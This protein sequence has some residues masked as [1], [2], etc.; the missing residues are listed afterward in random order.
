MTDPN[1]PIPPA[2]A[3]DEEELDMDEEDEPK[4]APRAKTTAAP[5]SGLVGRAWAA[6]K[7]LE[8]RIQQLTR[9]RVARVLKMARKPEPEEFRQSATIVLVGIAVI[10]ALGFFTYLFM[11]WL[12]VAI[13]AK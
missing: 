4:Q 7:N 9:G 3:A 5:N 12:L 2:N 8:G 13:G 1:Q 11:A 10:G 6:Q